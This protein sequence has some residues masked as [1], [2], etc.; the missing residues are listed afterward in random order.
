MHQI[1]ADELCVLQSDSP[2][3]LARL[4][5]SGG[6]RDLLVIY[7][8]KAAVSDNYFVGISPKIFHCISKTVEGFFNVR[9]PV[10]FIKAIA[11]PGP[12]VRISQLFTGRGKYQFAVFI[13]GIQ[14]SKIF[15]SEFVPEDLYRDETL[16][17]KEPDLQS[18]MACAA[19][20]WTSDWKQPEEQNAS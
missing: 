19:Y 14:F 1:T 2:A 16:M 18:M 20:F 8:N 12:S 5:P 15:P 6:K 11:K 13:K 3:R 17:P 9:A 4:P 7:R 10:L